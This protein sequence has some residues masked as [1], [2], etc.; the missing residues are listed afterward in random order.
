MEGS[1][2]EQTIISQSHFM[3]ELRVRIDNLI[4][5]EENCKK[6]MRSKRLCS[7]RRNSSGIHEE[8]FLKKAVTTIEAHIGDTVFTVDVYAREMGMSQYSSTAN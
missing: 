8:K 6:N 2:K 1:K 4:D 7:S 3:N 5:D